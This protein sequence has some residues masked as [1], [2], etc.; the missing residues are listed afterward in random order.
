VACYSLSGHT[1][2][3]A[4]ELARACNAD[5][6]I[7]GEVANRTGFL[8]HLRSVLQALMHLQPAIRPSRCVPRDYELVVVCTPVWAWNMAAP[9]RT[10]LRRHRAGIRR[11]ACVC[12]YAGSGQA[13]VLDDMARLCGRPPVATLAILTERIEQKTHGRRLHDF[14]SRVSEAAGFKWPAQQ[15]AA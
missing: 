3:L 4:M 8:G 13:K 14:A 2:R 1:R 11:V 5:V 10:W 7:I 6:E 12:T 15:D 9:M